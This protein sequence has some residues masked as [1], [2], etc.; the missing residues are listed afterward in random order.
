MCSGPSLNKVLSCEAGEEIRTGRVEN[1][2]KS[3]VQRGSV[4]S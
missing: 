2:P 3:G 1:V 4:E